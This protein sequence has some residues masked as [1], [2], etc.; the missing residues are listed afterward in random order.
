MA[1]CATNSDAPDLL[2]VHCA[3]STS[4]GTDVSNTCNPAK[5]A[6][7]TGEGS[8]PAAVNGPEYSAIVLLWLDAFLRALNQRP[9]F[10][11]SVLLV[12]L[13]GGMPLLPPTPH[14]EVRLLV[15]RKGN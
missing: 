5:R 1:E 3:A 10:R 12:V 8:I 9:G 2:L 13:L 4:A 14:E 15:I 11:E 7:G 6:A